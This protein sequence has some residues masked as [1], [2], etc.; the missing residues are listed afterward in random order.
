MLLSGGSVDAH[1]GTPI[2][3]KKQQ[4][5]GRDCGGHLRHALP[6][7]IDFAGRLIAAGWTKGEHLQPVAARAAGDNH[8]AGGN[9]GGTDHALGQI[10]FCRSPGDFAALDIDRITFALLSGGRQR[11]LRELANDVVP[12]L[13]ARAPVGERVATR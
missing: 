9:D 7:S 12:A 13:R 1:H 2:V 6:E 8:Q 10:V 11:R 5:A 3:P 4:L